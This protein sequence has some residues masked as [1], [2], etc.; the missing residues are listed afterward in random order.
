MATA[1]PVED[2][3]LP[4]PASAR[5]SACQDV[6]PVCR[7]HARCDKM[8]RCADAMRDSGIFGEHALVHKNI[9]TYDY[10][11]SPFSWVNQ[12]YMAMFNSYVSLPEGTKTINKK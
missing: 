9:Y 5:P 10:G 7:A 3:F 8:H 11:T 6:T 12:L 2:P 4:G 1:W